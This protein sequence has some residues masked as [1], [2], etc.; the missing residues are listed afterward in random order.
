MLR[1]GGVHSFVVPTH[2]RRCACAIN[3]QRAL[4]IGQSHA[5]T[6]LPIP[7]Q[8]RLP[9]CP[10]R[11]G[12]M[13]GTTMAAPAVCA[14]PQRRH[15]GGKDGSAVTRWASM[16]DHR[17]SCIVDLVWGYWGKRSHVRPSMCP[18][19]LQ[20]PARHTPQDAL[21]IP[22]FCASTDGTRGRQHIG[23]EVCTRTLRQWP[24]G[25]RL[26]KAGIASFVRPS[27]MACIWYGLTFC[28][29]P[30]A[31]KS[32]THSPTTGASSARASVT[33]GT[34]AVTPRTA[35]G[36]SHTGA[37]GTVPPFACANDGYDGAMTSQLGTDDG[38]DRYDG[39]MEGSPR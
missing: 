12:G 8:P 2:Q 32:H 5:G 15:G 36:G 11:H 7:R 4:P 16:A 27:I 9:G 30:S 13:S 33:G 38:Y 31:D 17:R 26:S 39:W 35:H 20:G 28:C 3:L 34:G 14:H 23:W 22:A 18:A 29:I 19:T 25:R 1:E 21:M 10:Y 24:A 6:L 37:G